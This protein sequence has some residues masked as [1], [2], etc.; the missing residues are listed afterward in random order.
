MSTEQFARERIWSSCFDLSHSYLH[1]G[2]VREWHPVTLPA[3]DDPQALDVVGPVRNVRLRRLRPVPH[4]VPRRDRPSLRKL[5]PSGLAMVLSVSGA[6]MVSP[7]RPP[8]MPPAP[9]RSWLRS[10]L[11][12][13]LLYVKRL[14]AS[15]A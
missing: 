2:P 5:R 6:R 12:L 1:G 10:D 15:G 14:E 7:Y 8:P 3:V 4:M 13:D 11:C 9:D